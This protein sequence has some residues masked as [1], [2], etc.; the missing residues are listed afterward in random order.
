MDCSFFS[1]AELI[2]GK[3]AVGSLE[4][5]DN[6]ELGFIGLAEFVEIGLINLSTGPR[7]K[8]ANF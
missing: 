2:T 8:S 7:L 6:C 1:S 5:C 3:E 4:E